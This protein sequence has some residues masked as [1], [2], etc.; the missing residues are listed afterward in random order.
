VPRRHDKMTT[1]NEVKLDEQGNPIVVDDKNKKEELDP[2]DPDLLKKMAEKLAN[3]QLADI[4]KKLDA[5]Y[6]ARDEALTK[7]EKANAEKREKEI[8]DLEAAGQHKEAFELKE[9]ELKARLKALEDRNTEL[10]RDATLK[11]ILMGYEF[12]NE[13]AAAMAYKSIVDELVKDEKGNWMHKSGVPIKDFVEVY[14]KDDANSFL[15]K[16]QTS[17]GAGLP[18]PKGGG[19]APVTNKTNSLFAKTQAEVLKMAE[20][21]QLPN[22]IKR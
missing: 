9:A 11:G 10:T 14:S 7:I 20:L 3:E 22:Q 21:G 19:G 1:E 17:S 16:A 18:A 4:K 2:N 8:K 12:R 13:N 15:F 6:A 5:A